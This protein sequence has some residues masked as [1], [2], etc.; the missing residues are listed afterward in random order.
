MTN[1]KDLDEARLDLLEKSKQWRASFT[2]LQA[3]KTS[4]MKELASTLTGMADTM[5]GHQSFILTHQKE[6]E[7]MVQPYL[8]EWT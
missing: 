2:V 8:Q 4:D 3:S 5:A 1:F 7:E 6:T